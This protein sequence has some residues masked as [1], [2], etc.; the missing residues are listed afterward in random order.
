[1]SYE[2]IKLGSIALGMLLCFLI[3]LQDI[4]TRRIH[5]FA[6]LGFGLCGI[7]FHWDRANLLWD[8]LLISLFCC[9]L[10]GGVVLF[11]KW[12]GKAKVMDQ[13][14]GW[15]DVIWFLALACWLSPF[16]FILFNAIS[17]L[18]TLTITLLLQW[19]GR[20]SAQF[21]IP[22]AACMG[23]CFMALKIIEAAGEF[24]LDYYQAVS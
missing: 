21:E 5:L 14:L 11:F 9:F 4:Q 22:L 3:I 8:I 7:G 18:I 1:M 20:I 16:D 12:K 13:M 10:V 24:W 23:A 19:R 6:L 2:W 15:G 17:Q